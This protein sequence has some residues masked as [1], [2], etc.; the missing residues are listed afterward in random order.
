MRTAAARVRRQGPHDGGPKGGGPRG[1]PQGAPPSGPKTSS[2]GSS[3]RS[4]GTPADKATSGL[5]GVGRQAPSPLSQEEEEE[6]ARCGMGC[7][8]GP[9]SRKRPSALDQ[10]GVD[11][12]DAEVEVVQDAQKGL[13]GRLRAEA[14]VRVFA[15]RPRPKAEQRERRRGDQRAG[16]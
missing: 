2:N 9:R 6:V 4:K 8:V 1:G 5:P 10:L 3:A 16:R 7:H 13:F 11:E 15:P 14:Q 12:Q